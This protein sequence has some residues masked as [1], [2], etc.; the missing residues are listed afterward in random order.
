MAFY[1]SKS[2]LVSKIQVP[3]IDLVN[4][5]LYIL[6]HCYSTSDRNT[7]LV[8]ITIAL[9]VYIIFSGVITMLDNTRI[10]ENHR[11][12]RNIT[13]HIRIRSNQNIIPD[14]YFADNCCI[15]ANPNAIAN[16]GRSLSHSAILLSNRYALVNI[17]ITT[18]YRFGIDCY[19]KRMPDI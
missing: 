7:H 11:M 8:S 2:I 3:C 13:I 4:N 14:C 9:S 1:T 10:A 18:N 16:Y 6:H 17:T 5:V 19:T 12:R 15:Y